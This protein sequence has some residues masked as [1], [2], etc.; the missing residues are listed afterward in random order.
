MWPFKP[1]PKVVTIC[2]DCIS[3]SDEKHKTKGYGECFL[4]GHKKH[5]YKDIDY[6]T[7]EEKT[8]AYACCVWNN[9]GNCF[10]FERKEDV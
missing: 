9:D 5:L 4:C 8:L 6:I 10:R 2:K 7:G 1:K 3:I